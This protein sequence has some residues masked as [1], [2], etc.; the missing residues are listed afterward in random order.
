MDAKF[1]DFAYFDLY[2]LKNKRQSFWPYFPVIVNDQVLF[3]CFFK[4]ITE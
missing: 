1:A 4:Y 2:I 3:K